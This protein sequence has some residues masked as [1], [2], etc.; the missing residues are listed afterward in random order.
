MDEAGVAAWKT[1]RADPDPKWLFHCEDTLYFL[2]CLSH[3]SSKKDTVH[4]GA[5]LTFK[6]FTEEVCSEKSTDLGIHTPISSFEI[7]AKNYPI[8]RMHKGQVRQYG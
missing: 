6:A 1:G 4:R 2:A 7:G 3:L 5:D 8:D